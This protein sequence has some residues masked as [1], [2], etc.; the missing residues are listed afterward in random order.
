MQLWTPNQQLQNGKFTIQKVLGGG[1]YGVTYSVLDAS[2]NQ[3]VAIKTLNPI[4]QSQADFEQQQVKF[5][6]EAFRLVQCNHPHIVKVHEVVNENGLWGMVM[7]YIRGQD[8]AEYVNE[9]GK[10]PEE[11]ALRYIKQIGI[12]LEYIH[13]QGMLHRDVKPNNIVLRKNQQEAVLI[14]FGLAREFN[15]N[16]TGS[17]TN[18]KTEGYA[19]IEQYERRGK[20]GAYTDVYALAATLYALLTGDTPLPANFRRTGIPLPAPKQRNPRISDRVND[21]IIKGMGLEPHE[22]TPT[23]KEWLELI[24]PTVQKPKEENKPPQKS[25]EVV[26]TPQTPPKVENKLPQKNPVQKSQEVVSKPQTPPKVENKPPQ[27]IQFQKFKFEYAKIE[28]KLQIIKY[29]GEAEYFTEDLGNG[30]SLDMVYIPGGSFIMGTEDAEIERLMKKFDYYRLRSERPQHQVNVPA[31]C[32]GKYPITQV[33]W[34][35]VAALPKINRDLKPEPSRFK[36]DNRPVEKL[37][38]YDAVEFCARL[39]KATGR[40]YRLPSEAEWEYAC[41]A[42]TTTPFHFGEIITSELANYRAT[43]TFANEPKGKCREQTTDVG[44][45]PPNAFGLYDMH[46]NVSEWCLDDWHDSYQ[47][48]TIDGSAW[49]KNENNN[50]Y[51]KRVNAVLRSGSWHTIPAVCRSA[52]RSNCDRRDNINL[53]IG[54]RL[55]CVS[56]RT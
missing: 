36:G 35:R 56:G 19:P 42:G 16:Q 4:H 27:K 32:M 6:Q 13:Q 31:F 3:T 33:Q 49:F 44:I 40:E 14:D 29:P 15:L 47:G 30:I 5:V 50:L 8:L 24:T 22:R 26:S 2:R 46:G 43:N 28:K 52:S 25:P 7:E 1:G 20:F 48:A 23:V 37:S 41:R 11:K 38:W 21:G 55:V 34:K 17:M 18:S 54:F 39:S 10:L 51:Q 12:A 45:F 53:N 9:N